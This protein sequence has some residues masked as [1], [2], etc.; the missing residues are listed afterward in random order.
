MLGQ[1]QRQDD[2]PYIR[3]VEFVFYN[4]AEI[5]LSILDARADTKTPE[6]RNGSGLPDPTATTAV[7]NLS[8]IP[9]VFIHGQELKYPERWTTVVDKTY[10]WCKRQGN[11]YFEIARARYGGAHFVKICSTLDVTFTKFYEIVE[12][13]KIYAALQAAQLNLIYVD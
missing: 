5:R 4:E 7:R 12:K 11:K 8:E 6:L 9:V 10:A 13:V 2:R 3:K 1:K